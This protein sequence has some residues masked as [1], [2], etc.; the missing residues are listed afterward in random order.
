MP[1]MERSWNRFVRYPAPR[2]HGVQIYRDVDELAATVAAYLAAGFEQGEPAVVVATPVHWH[3]VS[4]RLEQ[5]GWDA[6]AAD[7]HGLVV[8]ADA[9]ATLAAIMVDGKL[10]A[11]AF[12]E[13]VGG[14]LGQA[15]AR[16]P[17]KQVRVFGEM[18]DLLVG[19]ENLEGAV[20]LEEEWHR[21]L[22]RRGCFSLLCAYHI[23]LFDPAA[24]VGLLPKV[25]RAHSHVLPADDP[26]RFHRAV[27]AA[28]EETLGATDAGRI[29]AM[30]ADQIRQT[31][32]PASQLALMWVSVE[33]PAVAQRVLSS[34]QTKYLQDAA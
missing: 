9:E 32:V 28:L 14:L 26:E 15:A 25:C 13:V 27:D 34:A 12:A 24:Q 1:P 7:E 4:E 21:L 20:A 2:E 19:H 11:A 6:K 8:W 22:E 10:S 17:Y 30:I 23:D 16:F 31:P 3:C 18:V 5:S 33:M 29:Y